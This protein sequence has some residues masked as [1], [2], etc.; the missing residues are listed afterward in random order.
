MN[1]VNII[2]PTVQE[3]FEAIEP[4]E[5]ETFI[6]AAL[7]DDFPQ[8]AKEVPTYAI[9]VD[10]YNALLRQGFSDLRLL[11]NQEGKFRIPNSQAFVE[12]SETLEPTER[13]LHVAT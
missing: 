1:I 4:N 12:R 2:A 7:E 10:T 8:V 3:A 6:Y 9:G 11:I 13:R 5:H